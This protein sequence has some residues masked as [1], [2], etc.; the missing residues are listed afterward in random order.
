MPPSKKVDEKETQDK[1]NKNIKT[2]SSKKNHT[3]NKSKENKDY[4][5]DI[6]YK[7]DLDKIYENGKND[8]SETKINNIDKE[9]VNKIKTKDV[10]TYKKRG[11]KSK[12]HKIVEKINLESQSDEESNENVEY[13]E[14]IDNTVLNNILSKHSKDYIKVLS[15]I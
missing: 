7:N 11:R 4:L 10:T 9:V 8:N 15:R 2:Y 12:K 6:L 13:N 1:Y 5:R 14:N 3:E